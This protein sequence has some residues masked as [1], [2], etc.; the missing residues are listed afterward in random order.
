[1][2]TNRSVCVSDQCKGISEW[3]SPAKPG[4]GL[5]PRPGSAAS[6]QQYFPEID[7]SWNSIYYPPRKGEEIDAVHER[8]E[9]FLQAFI[10]HVERTLPGEQHSR[11]MLVSHAATSI[12]LA[13]ALVGDRNLPLRVGC[14]T[15]SEFDRQNDSENSY[16]WKAV[17]LADGSPL[18]G[19][20]AR[21]WGF[22]DVELANGNVVYDPGTTGNENELDEPVGLQILTSKM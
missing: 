7:P 18:S 11:V 19:G 10:P 8:A 3:Y 15:V 5:H 13:R 20:A 21:D 16:S 9:S 1:M 12:V 4:S 22:E 14:C 17:R 2:C 6:L